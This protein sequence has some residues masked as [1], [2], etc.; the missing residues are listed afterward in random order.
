MKENIELSRRKVLLGLGTIGIASAGAGAGTMALFE[1]SENAQATVQAGTLDL[2][3]DGQ[4]GN[5]PIELPEVAPGKTTS[6]EV[7]LRN[8]GSVTGMLSAV[9][10]SIEDHENGRGEAEREED[11]DGEGELSEYLEVAVGYGNW[12]SGWKTLQ[13]VHGE[14][15]G[16]WEFGGFSERTVT[17]RCRLPVTAPNVV[18]SDRVTVDMAFSLVQQTDNPVGEEV[19][20]EDYE[21]GW[22]PTAINKAFGAEI[23]VRGSYGL[24][25]KGNGGGKD[26]TWGGSQ[27]FD[28]GTAYDFALTAEDGTVELEAEGKGSRSVSGY[29]FD[30][31]LSQLVV[32]A[33]PLVDDVSVT[34]ENLRINGMDAVPGTISHDEV[35]K[36]M[37]EFTDLDGSN[38]LTVTG[39]V[40]FDYPAGTPA[41]ENVADVYIEAS[42]AQ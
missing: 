31:D 24:A 37:F 23:D 21:S 32:I 18:Q 33:R 6:T 25:L 19:F 5:V 16:P 2:T 13:S 10:T 36:R 12:T 4:D 28:S 20:S 22:P 41:G 34:V 38:G 40:T 14:S 17:V 29:N 30:G 9:V 11:D 7:T 8:V 3:I 42:K 15:Y 35:S 39:T 26:E 27:A 1:D